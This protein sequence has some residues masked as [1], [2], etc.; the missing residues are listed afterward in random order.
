VRLTP[1][2]RSLPAEEVEAARTITQ[3]GVRLI[4]T[5]HG[6]TL[7]EIVND[8]ERR[9]L[10]GG[11]SNATL[12]DAAAE[13]RADKRKSVALRLREPSFSTAIEVHE[14]ERWVFHPCLR[15][16]ID[17]FFSGEP[18]RCQVLMPGRSLAAFAL[19]DKD[20]FTYCLECGRLDTPCAEHLPPKPA[21]SP[22]A[23]GRQ[24]AGACYGCGEYG[25]IR[26]H[27]TAGRVGGGLNLDFRG[28]R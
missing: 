11:Q 26:M 12:T 27:C 25:H 1:G 5:V 16:A 14:R 17:G 8:P 19:P 22:A 21:A 3:R 9:N 15:T 24:V 28:R 2:R 10:V 4:A 20:A 13:R 7:P 6:C 18:V 23:G